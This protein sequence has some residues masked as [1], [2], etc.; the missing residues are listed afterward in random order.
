MEL[1]TTKPFPAEVSRTIME[2][3]SVGT[4]S[5]LTPEGWPLGIG[6][7]FAVDPEGIPVL[8]LNGSERKFSTDSRS[9]LH[10]QVSPSVIY[11]TFRVYFCL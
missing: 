7:R 10:V 4:L 6:V 11:N 5:T 1:K 2:L 3:G 8:C 9:S